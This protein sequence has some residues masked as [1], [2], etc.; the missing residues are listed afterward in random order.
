[1]KV[2]QRAGRSRRT[3]VGDDQRCAVARALSRGVLK[4][5]GSKALGFRDRI[6][7]RQLI[8]PPTVVLTNLAA[9]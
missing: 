3:A 9:L 4:V 1:L 6:L 5:R 2:K 7:H 8:L